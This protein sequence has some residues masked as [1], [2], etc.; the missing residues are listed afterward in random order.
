MFRKEHLHRYLAIFIAVNKDNFML[1]GSWKAP[2]VPSVQAAAFSL[3]SFIWTM[4]EQIQKLSSHSKSLSEIKM[5]PKAKK[6]PTETHFQSQ[7]GK[8]TLCFWSS[9]YGNNQQG[10]NPS[11]VIGGRHSVI[12]KE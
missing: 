1:Q 2:P 12:T 6:A 3:L 10:R 7:K 5:F 8:A 4:K 11:V 9:Q